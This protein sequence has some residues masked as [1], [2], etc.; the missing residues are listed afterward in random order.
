[1]NKIKI[2]GFDYKFGEV[3][4][5]ARD[6]EALGNSCYNALTINIDDGVDKSIKAATIIHEIIE[7][8]DSI[9]E[10]D[11]EHNKITTLANSLYEV[12]IDN[13]KMIEEYFSLKRINEEV[14]L[15]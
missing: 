11:L 15:E 9:N 12:I 14:K 5:L 6:E 3:K 4:N 1:M 7:Q 13:P 2:G 8:I 10:L